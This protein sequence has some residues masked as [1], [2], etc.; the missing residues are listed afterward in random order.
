MEE[1]RAILI[2]HAKR[3]PLMQPTDAEMLIYQNELGG[4]YLIRDEQACLNYLRREY[5]DL[6][7]SQ[8]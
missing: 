6:G 8:R 5:A 2:A 3:Y 4:G 7:K 1:R